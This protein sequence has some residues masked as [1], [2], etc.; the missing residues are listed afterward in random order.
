MHAAERRPADPRESL[1]QGIIA[2]GYAG[3][4]SVQR[5]ALRIRTLLRGIVAAVA[6][7]AGLAALDAATL[8]D[9]DG[10]ELFRH[11]CASCHGETGRGD[12]PVAPGLANAVPDLTRLTQRY[13]EFPAAR[14]RE[15]IDGRSV[16]VTA[17]GTRAMPVWGHELWVEQGADVNAERAARE[18]I[19]KLVDY[20]RSLQVESPPNGR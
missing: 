20:V 11:F 5:S 7:F 15:S 16:V 12:G 17:H 3:T 1:P 18:A 2:R 14:V 6:F 4:Q 8:E 19:R 13:G 10:P 9:Y